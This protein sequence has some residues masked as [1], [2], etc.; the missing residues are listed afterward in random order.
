VGEGL[1]AGDGVGSAIKSPDRAERTLST[2]AATFESLPDPK[3]AKQIIISETKGN[4][5]R[6]RLLHPA[7]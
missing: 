6:V 3:M 7:F 4:K 1:E 5:I 2:D